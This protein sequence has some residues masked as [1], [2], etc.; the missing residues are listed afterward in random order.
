MNYLV[1]FLE[2]SSKDTPLF[3]NITDDEFVK[4]W[5]KSKEHGAE[6]LS[7]KE[8]VSLKELLDK[9]FPSFGG[10]VKY[11][12]VD[13][14]LIAWKNYYD[15]HR[16]LLNDQPRKIVIF[17]DSDDWYYIKI[18]SYMFS[19]KQADFAGLPVAR[20]VQD[21]YIHRYKCDSLLGVE[22]LFKM[23]KSLSSFKKTQE[24]LYQRLPEWG[25]F[26]NKRKS[27]EVWISQKMASKIMNLFQSFGDFK[28]QFRNSFL[29]SE[30]QDNAY[31]IH[32]L[33][34]DYFLVVTWPKSG[35]TYGLPRSHLLNRY[36]YC[37]G[38][39][40]LE[41][42]LNSILP[43][44]MNESLYQPIEKNEKSPLRYQF[45]DNELS[46]IQKIV[47]DLDFIR[48]H[49]NIHLSEDGCRIHLS[50]EEFKI[51]YEYQIFKKDS[52]DEWYYITYGFQTYLCDGL[53]GIKEFMEENQPD[54]DWDLYV[55]NESLH[56]STEK[57]Y[58]QLYWTPGNPS[59][60]DIKNYN[61]ITEHEADYIIDLIDK[62][63]TLLEIDDYKFTTD[64]HVLNFEMI[65]RD[66]VTVR[67]IYILCCKDQDDYFYLSI[68]DYTSQL[69]RN[70]ITF[71]RCDGLAGVEELLQ[72]DYQKFYFYHIHL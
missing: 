27:E 52:D 5:K 63:L 53:D 60:D 36:Y 44:N 18:A 20:E 25:D 46:K 4:G 11:E 72:K 40:G 56:N 70:K 1:G 14:H 35:G 55:V 13:R 67:D 37:D 62:Y 29:F 34:D 45:S 26:E 69:K 31:N 38:L 9:F 57:L 47:Q 58:V 22:D 19:H 48:D 16:N 39:Q 32:Q 33:R 7:K 51:K 2:S 24:S 28:F 49:Y 17:K 10:H 41:D 61:T 43:K 15:V 65:H 68:V 59:P 54:P 8:I 3:T 50:N 64:R 30:D 23:L 12:F 42:L 71:F 21:T 66:R 6:E